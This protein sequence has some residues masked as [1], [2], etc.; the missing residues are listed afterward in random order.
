MRALRGVRRSLPLL[1]VPLA[2]CGSG[3]T[4]DSSAFS[5]RDSAGIQIAESSAP[6]WKAGEEWTVGAEPTVEIGVV[7]GAP[8]YQLNR[9]TDA[10]RQSS[11]QIVVTNSAS[12]EIRLYDASGRH[13]RTVGGRGG[14]PGE[15]Q[16]LLYTK[17]LPGD[18]LIAF[19]LMP[20]RV[21][22]FSPGG[23]FVRSFQLESGADGAFPFA[24]G[25]L[26][27]GSV[28][29]YIPQSTGKQ[30]DGLQRP[31]Q[32]FLHY[33]RDG[34]MLDTVAVQPG[35]ERFVQTQPGKNGT[36]SMSQIPPMF[37]H[38]PVQA[39]NN[40]RVVFGENESYELAMYAP[41]GVVKRL[42]RRKVA[43]R[44]VTDADFASLLDTRLAGYSDA[45][46]RREMESTYRSLPRP[47]I[48]PFYDT[49]L[50]DDRA[51]LWVR[52]FQPAATTP[53]PWTVFDPEGRMLGTVTLP[54]GL[55]TMQIGD[56][57]V[58]GVWM[59]DLDVQHVRMYALTKPA[60]DPR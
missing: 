10:R 47:D 17:L 27:D 9:V 25:V 30:V 35:P 60:R 56:D 58:L 46:R 19:D 8:E 55:R 16:T 24:S 54:D 44:P 43:P 34:K 53:L 28:I 51:N 22:I 57:F 45:A 40:D 23:D 48:M 38:N 32:L 1:L 2:A 59:D 33:S 14:G 37:S 50:F 31:S 52:E 49:V 20:Q 26:R 3:E 7:D 5:V 4:S 39:V 6:A 41:D 29:A 18:S 42:V 15:F 11:G 12:N 13:L 36:M 21:S